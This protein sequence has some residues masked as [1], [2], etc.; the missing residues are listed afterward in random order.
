M[1]FSF[2]EQVNVMCFVA[3]LFFCGSLLKC[4][5]PKFNYDKIE[6]EESLVSPSHHN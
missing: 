5:M 3:L 4:L 2:T 6:M 1:S